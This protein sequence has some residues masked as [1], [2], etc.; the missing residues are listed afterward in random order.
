LDSLAIVV[1]LGNPGERYRGTR[2]NVGYWV[3][4]RLAKRSGAAFRAEGELRR[5]A[6]FAE[7]RLGD[8]DVVLAKPRTYMNRSGRAV[9]GL[10][11]AYSFEPEQLLIVH[12]DADLEI[13]R[14]RIRKG[15]GA[16]G[17]NGVRSL[18]EVLG[19]GEFTRIRV[20]VRGPERDEE[21][22]ADYVLSDFSEED[23]QVAEE[24][25]DLAAEAVVFLLEDGVTA[26]MNRYNGMK[27]AGSNSTD[28]SEG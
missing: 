23:R 12:D 27:I 15:G 8:S 5:Y 13:G 11:R 22:L 1:G 4:D 17:H 18:V 20:G 7:T 14:L 19:N 6:W 26:A 21:E 16:G 3:L 25:C 9:S 10:C 28:S 2:H 24:V